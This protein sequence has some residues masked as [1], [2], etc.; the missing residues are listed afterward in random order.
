M[1]EAADAGGGANPHRGE[2]EVDLE[3]VAHVLRPTYEALAAIESGTGKGLIAL[4]IA[5]EAGELSL[6]DAALI[7]TECVKAHGKATGDRTTAGYNVRRVG[8]CIMATG[9]LLVIKRIE[10]LLMLAVTGGYDAS[11]N[12]QALPTAGTAAP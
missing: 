11:G 3:G 9:L 10:I 12:R 4:G 1:S 6:R 7:V 5:A 8:E 2:I